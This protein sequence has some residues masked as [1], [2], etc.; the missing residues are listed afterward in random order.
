MVRKDA[1]G[2]NWVVISKFSMIDR[3]W[4]WRGHS[5][6]RFV[7]LEDPCSDHIALYMSTFSILIHANRILKVAIWFVVITHDLHIEDEAI[8]GK[9][10][11]C[12]LCSQFG[13]S[14]AFVRNKQLCLY[15]SR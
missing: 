15:S 3:D 8:E 4:R 14:S 13:T 7:T 11:K 10:S 12:S 6:T 9:K 5:Y 1:S 2:S